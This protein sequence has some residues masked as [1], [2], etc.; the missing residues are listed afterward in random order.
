MKPLAA[1][2]AHISTPSARKQGV[3]LNVRSS[4]AVEGISVATFRSAKTGASVSKG[5]DAKATRAP[6][7][8]SAKKK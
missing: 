1:S 8:A 4:S 3:E 5:A 7:R 2:N 6:A